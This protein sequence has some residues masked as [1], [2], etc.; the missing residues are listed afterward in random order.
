MMKL[1]TK[2]LIKKIS[3]MENRG[4]E[5]ESMLHTLRHGGSYVNA[6]NLERVQRW[7]QA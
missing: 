7:L 1:V 4:A 2:V 6:E 3:S 5:E